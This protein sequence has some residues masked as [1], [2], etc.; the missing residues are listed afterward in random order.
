MTRIKSNPPNKKTHQ[1]KTLAGVAYMEDDA[2]AV[3]ATTLDSAL[4][5]GTARMLAQRVYSSLP[6]PPVSTSAPLSKH[7]AAA[8]S[9]PPADGADRIS[10]LPDDILRGVVSRL[11]ARD[12]ARTTALSKH[13]TGVWRSVP[14]VLVD[15]HL[16][17]AAAGLPD[18]VS[19]ALA[20]HP[21]PFRC[22]HLTGT[23]M[24]ARRN[25]V[26]RWL[27]LLAA[28][29]ARELVFVNRPTPIRAHLQLPGALFTCTS[30]TRLYL[31]FWT[32][33]GT[34]TVPPAAV[35]FPRL[36]ELGL[37]SVAIEE[38]DL[39]FLLENKC[40]VL[41]KLVVVGSRWRPVPIRIRSCSLRCVQ[42]C[43][44][45]VPEIDVGHAPVLERLLLCGVSGRIC[46]LFTMASRIKIGY[47]PNLRLLG[48]L[49][50]GMHEPEITGN[51]NTV[52]P[53]VQMVGVQ[54]KLGT[55]P[56]QGHDGASFPQMLS[57]HGDALYPV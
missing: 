15:A 2:V 43:S 40:P 4:M 39:A 34:G 13:W 27:Q 52:L 30:L 42:V 53:S 55:R 28:K 41:E 20:A 16:L 54:V 19:R 25:E 37:G 6:A 48:F 56:H 57:Q 9:S 33:P 44:S 49:V 50:P 22:V 23:P 18:T 32:F 45:T 10:G 3:L 8:A 1:S 24:A 29:G 17:P 36:R 38:W 12:A 5:D 47:A 21:G 14:L 35:S 26:T 51:T 11:P 31:G 7:A 46:G